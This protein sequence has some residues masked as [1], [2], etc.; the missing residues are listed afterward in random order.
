MYIFVQ[1]S[2]CS[3]FYSN[4]ARAERNSIWVCSQPAI[5]EGGQNFSELT[6]FVNGFSVQFSMQIQRIFLIFVHQILQTK[7]KS[8]TAIQRLCFSEI[9]RVVS[10]ALE[11]QTGGFESSLARYGIEILCIR[12]SLMNDPSPFI[13]SLR[14]KQ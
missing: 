3:F 13:F 5:I 12:S 14:S 10:G 11:V 4:T 8:T 9:L 2:N 1:K 6:R 7:S